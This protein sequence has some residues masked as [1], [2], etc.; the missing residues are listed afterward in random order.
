MERKKNKKIA[1]MPETAQ[2]EAELNRERYKRRYRRVM[3]STIYALIITAAVSVLIATL[4]I[5]ILR[6]T[7][8]SM[9]PTL[10]DGE[11]V[12]SVK[13]GKF[14]SGDLVSFYIGNKILIKRII[15]LPGQWINIDN[16]GKVYINEQLLAEPYLQEAAFGDCDIKFPYQVPENHY[17]VM[18]DHRSTSVDSRSNTV[19]CVSEEQIVGKIVYRI[20]PFGQFGLL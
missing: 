7:G 13:G 18:G 1:A 4:W 17:F 2:L 14:D 8:S 5:P 12:I 19:G 20:W 11:I 3:R 10:N 6:I 9:T 16:D 15:G